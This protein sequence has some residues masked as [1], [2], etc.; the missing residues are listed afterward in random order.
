MVKKRTLRHILSLLAVAVLLS[1]CTAGNTNIE[2]S[3]LADQLVEKFRITELGTLSEDLVSERYGLNT[4]Q[5]ESWDIREGTGSE[6]DTLIAVLKLKEK[7]DA[8]QA[9]ESLRAGAKAFAQR[10]SGGPDDQY[11]LARSPVV[12]QSGNYVFL[13]IGADAEQMAEEFERLTH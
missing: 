3:E 4:D 12:S 8:P 6:K 10:F 9:E 13:A 2:P 5:L 7:E 11:E 1:G